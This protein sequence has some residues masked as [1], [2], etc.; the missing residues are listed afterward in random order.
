[1]RDSTVLGVTTRYGI[2]VVEACRSRGGA[3]AVRYATR[4]LLLQRQDDAAASPPRFV[5]DAGGPRPS[6]FDLLSVQRSSWSDSTPR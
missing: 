1:M 4:T 3:F 2:G 6:P 5:T